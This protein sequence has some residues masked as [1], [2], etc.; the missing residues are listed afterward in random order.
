M[1]PPL[2]LLPLLCG[3]V[4]EDDMSYDVR[5]NIKVE[6]YQYMDGP[7]VSFAPP[8]DMGLEIV[9]YSPPRAAGHAKMVHMVRVF[10]LT[11]TSM[12]TDSVTGRLFSEWCFGH[13]SY[14]K[15]HIAR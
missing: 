9:I 7:L 5:R 4:S 11:H 13:C 12:V 10:V 14:Q 2:D 8:E 15:D 6:R 3:Q 1:A